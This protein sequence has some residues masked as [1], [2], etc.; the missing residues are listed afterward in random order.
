M[1][2]A[3]AFKELLKL[4]CMS[5]KDGRDTLFMKSTKWMFRVSALNKSKCTDVKLS[6][7][8][9]FWERGAGTSEDGKTCPS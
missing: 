7:P 6:V 9:D 5:V 1:K 2:G 8:G 3:S 4:T